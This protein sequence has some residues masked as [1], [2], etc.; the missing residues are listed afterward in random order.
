MMRPNRGNRNARDQCA[1]ASPRVT[2]RRRSSSSR[3][4]FL[5]SNPAFGG[6]GSLRFLRFLACDDQAFDIAMN[7]R[8]GE[9]YAALFDADRSLFGWEWLRRDS[10]YRAAA[11][12]AAAARVA[13]AAAGHFGLVGFEPPD[14]AVPCARPLWRSD[15]NPQVLVSEL[16]RSGAGE[17]ELNLNHLSHLA[18]VFPDGEIDHLLL[19]DGLHAIRVDAPRG[20]FSGQPLCFRFSVDRLGSSEVQLLALRRLLVLVRNGCFARSL[21]R[22]EPRARRWILQLRAHDA[23]AAGAEIREIA[24]VL[25]GRSSAGTGWRTRDPSLR[26]QAQRM[27][28]SARLMAQGGFRHLL[29]APSNIERERRVVSQSRQWS[30][31]RHLSPAPS[32]LDLGRSRAHDVDAPQGALIHG[33]AV[34]KWGRELPTS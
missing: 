5:Y 28:R 33:P 34:L 27:V 8:D 16:G 23:L 21:H 25:L 22:R 6:I 17:G 24:E 12:V 13:S 26:S 15:F 31:Q 14:V 32:I 1:R 3:V 7:W 4:P 29:G 19:T 18:H 30:E 9:A 2:D 10:T 20:T 11:S